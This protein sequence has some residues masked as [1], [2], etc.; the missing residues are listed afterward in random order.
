VSA[1]DVTATVDVAF[2]SVPTGGGSWAY[3]LVRQSTSGN[4]Q[5]AVK[6]L[7]TSTTV[8]LRK[9]VGTTTTTIAQKVLTMSYAAGDRLRMRLQVSGTSPTQLS[10]KV[11][12]VGT[13][14]PS[15]WQVVGTDSTAALQA[16]GRVGLQAYL[17][18]SSTTLPVVASFD[19][20]DVR[21]S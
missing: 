8:Q 20:L 15:G 9:V 18:G 17:S 11:W 16:V 1:Q 13:T 14:E 5:I 4:Y 21:P 10:G 2:D 19:N 6:V 7:P 12:K 3:L